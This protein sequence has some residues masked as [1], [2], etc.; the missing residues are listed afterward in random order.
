M[1]D[2][3]PERKGSRRARA[4]ATRRR[5]IDAAYRQFSD[6]GYVATTLN[7]IAAE[8]GVAEQTVR[9]V[10]HTKAELLRHVIEWAAAGEPDPLP[11]MERAWA[12]EALHAADGH[13]TLELIAQHGVDIYA[14]MAPLGPAVMSAASLD[15]DIAGYWRSISEG[16]RAGSRLFIDA[17]AAGGQLRPELSRDRAADILYVINSH[18][19]FLGLTAGSGWSLGEFKAW[20]YETLCLLLLPEQARR[21]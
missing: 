1:T 8:A 9:F 6:S 11:V 16:R 12:V 19:T 14:R 3:N 17:L 21:R 4:S 18:E 7:A 13:R 2:V 15:A 10:F 20:L 5:I